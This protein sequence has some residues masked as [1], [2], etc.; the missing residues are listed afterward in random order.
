MKSDVKEITKASG[1]KETDRQSETVRQSSVM[2]TDN[3]KNTPSDKK[4]TVFYGRLSNA[5]TCIVLETV[6]KVYRT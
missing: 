4:M 5:M 3:V 2:S 6:S 1:V